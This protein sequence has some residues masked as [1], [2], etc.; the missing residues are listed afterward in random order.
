MVLPYDM[1]M[2]FVTI[3]ISEI[4]YHLCLNSICPKHILLNKL[5][6]SI[7]KKI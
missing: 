3:N 7:K 5:T 1:T 2:R 6:F 4:K